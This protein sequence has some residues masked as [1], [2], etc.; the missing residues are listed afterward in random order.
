MTEV[1]QVPH[2]HLFYA[3]GL[4]GE[5]AGHRYSQA[6]PGAGVKGRLS[7]AQ[8]L[9]AY[10][11]YTG[12]RIAQNQ[13]AKTYGVDGRTVQRAVRDI[14]D[15]RENVPSFD[16]SLASAERLCMAQFGVKI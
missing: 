13:I 9:A 1:K 5:V 12:M 7:P 2:S 4:V 6:L 8:K 11:L 16:E 3:C 15:S 14:V 10:L